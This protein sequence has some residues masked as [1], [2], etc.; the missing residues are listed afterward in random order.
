VG[1]AVVTYR[2]IEVALHAGASPGPPPPLYV[3]ILLL[4]GLIAFCAIFVWLAVRHG[5]DGT[6]DSDYGDLG[7]G[8]GGGPTPPDPSPNGD[9][10]WWSEFEREFA[11]YVDGQRVA[12]AFSAARDCRNGPGVAAS[13]R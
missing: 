8:W 3:S 7:G 9:P 1:I 6:G 11:A 2:G 13:A 4:S 10:E 12:A 5:E